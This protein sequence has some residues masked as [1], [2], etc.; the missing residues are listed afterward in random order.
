MRKAKSRS[1][2]DKEKEEAATAWAFARKS[3]SGVKVESKGRSRPGV[4]ARQPKPKFLTL[5]NHKS[6]ECGARRGRQAS[7]QQGESHRASGRLAPLP[8][9]RRHLLRP[10]HRL[11]RQG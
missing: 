3:K 11:P 2:E 10:R 1:P 8:V 5:P 4:A 9:S 7:L 6:S